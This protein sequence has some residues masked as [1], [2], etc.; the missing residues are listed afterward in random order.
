MPTFMG[1]QR[2]ALPQTTISIDVARVNANHF[3]R[4]HV[5]VPQMIRRYRDALR[6]YIY[7]TLLHA[8][9]PPH[10]LAMGVAIGMFVTFTPT[11]GFQ[12]VLVVLLAWLLRANKVAGVPVVWI[13]NPATLVPIFFSCYV[14]GQ[15]ILGSEPIGQAWWTELTTPPE[16]WF[17]AVSFYWSKLMEIAVPL[18]TGSLV[19]GLAIAYP[20]YYLVYFSVRTYRRRRWGQ[21]L[22]PSA[23]KATESL[24]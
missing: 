8:D 16:G 4:L 15:M 20:T 10:R 12:M 13:S 14:V 11:V 24:P 22:P 1:N 18:W 21:D 23:T 2:F 5:F 7:H 9:D 6:H 3:H 17:P 19:V